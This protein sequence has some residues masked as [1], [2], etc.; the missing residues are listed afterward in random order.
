MLDEIR[1]LIR[2]RKAA[3]PSG[4]AVSRVSDSHLGVEHHHSP[5]RASGSGVLIV[6]KPSGLVMVNTPTHRDPF[7]DVSP[8]GSLEISGDPYSGLLVRI[9]MYADPRITRRHTPKRDSGSGR[10]PEATVPSGT[11]ADD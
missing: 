7:C 8:L 2:A 6:P 3:R 10:A 9:C 1:T 4:R 11:E 5:P